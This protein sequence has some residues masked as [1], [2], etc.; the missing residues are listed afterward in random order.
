LS[1]WF[2]RARAQI[3]FGFAIWL[4]AMGLGYA[5]LPKGHV[6][7]L[8]CLITLSVSTGVLFTFG[9]VSWEAVSNPRTD[10]S[11]LLALGAFL[12]SLALAILAGWIIGYRAIYGYTP[13]LRE[14]WVFIYVLAISTYGGVLYLVS[15]G[16][17][18]GN[19]PSREWVKGGLWVA[20]GVF[21]F[22]VFLLLVT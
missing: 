19:I 12:K 16:A 18:P 13:Q 15:E 10:T 21:L 2:E 7:E 9:P 20:G 5:L 22:G 4:A 17:L 3:I 14:S 8:L 6:I 11:D 1:K